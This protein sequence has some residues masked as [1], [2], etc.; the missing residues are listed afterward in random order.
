M[1]RRLI[2]LFFTLLSCDIF[3]Q[4]LEH[5]ISI[6]TIVP[7]SYNKWRTNIY[8]SGSWSQYRNAK[9][10]S[11]YN[12][13]G[14]GFSRYY[15]GNLCFDIG[16]DIYKDRGMFFEGNVGYTRSSIGFSKNMF[17]GE[18]MICHWASIDINISHIAALDGMLNVGIKSSLLLT[19]STPN[20][21][22]MLFEDFQSDCFHRCSLTPYV[23]ARFRLQY[24]KFDIRIGGQAI[25]YL[26]INKIAKTRINKLYFEVRL[27]VKIFSSSNPSR[28]VNTLFLDMLDD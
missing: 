17:S 4:E 7:S 1:K 2:F 25:P 19:S 18:N 11:H 28:P 14:K 10:G 20:T 16:A 12:N 8:T 22:N 21:K 23:G 13:T 24:F 27:G 15:Q 6:D 3:A 9:Y 26:N 5:V